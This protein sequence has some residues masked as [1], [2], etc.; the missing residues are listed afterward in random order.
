MNPVVIRAAMQ[1][2]LLHPVIGGPAGEYRPQLSAVMRS[3]SGSVLVAELDGEIVG[4]ITLGQ[5]GHDGDISGFIVIK[6]T[7]RQGIGTT[8]MDAA[9]DEARRR[10]CKRLRLTVAKVNAG[11]IALYAERGYQRVAQGMSAGLRT[12]EGVVVHPP[13][14]VWEMT[15]P[16]D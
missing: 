15:K 12:P 7:R 4:R 10:G 2:D 11:A 13:E 14:P 1:I 3:H 6:R 9:E 5:S 16:I 8:L